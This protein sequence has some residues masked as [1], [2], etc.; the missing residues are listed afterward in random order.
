MV[1]HWYTF[2]EVTR[3]VDV[4]KSVGEHRGQVVAGKGNHGQEGKTELDVGA[5]NYRPP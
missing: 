4:V 5:N 2:L 1:T 3:G